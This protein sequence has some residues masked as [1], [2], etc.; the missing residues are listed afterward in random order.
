[1]RRLFAVAALI[2]ISGCAK[3]KPIGSAPGGVTTLDGA[4]LAALEADFDR[5]KDR[6]RIVALL[7]PS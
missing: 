1:M 3:P 7:S 6:P 2:A 4:Q 5:K